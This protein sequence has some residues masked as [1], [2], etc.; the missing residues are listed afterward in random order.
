MKIIPFVVFLCFLGNTSYAQLN[1]DS[2]YH[3]LDADVPKA[4]ISI[5]PTYFVVNEVRFGF[6]YGKETDKQN[7]LLGGFVGLIGGRVSSRSRNGSP[8]QDEDMMAGVATELHTKFLF[9]GSSYSG[10]WWYVKPYLAGKLVNYTFYEDGWMLSNQGNDNFY[11]IGK[12]EYYKETIQYGFGLDI[13]F[14]IYESI[15]PIV[16]D[17]Y[18]GTGIRYTS[19]S[20]NYSNDTQVFNDNLTSHAYNGTIFRA[21]VIVGFAVK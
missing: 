9:G 14:F 7:Y 17:F 5:N 15:K 16:I 4:T 11:G 3:K 2:I 21:G 12:V 8:Y 13:G 1:L 6:E 18:A 19:N 10:T 20:T